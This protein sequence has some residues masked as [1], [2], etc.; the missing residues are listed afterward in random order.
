MGVRDTSSSVALLELQEPAE[1]PANHL[2]C[3]PIKSSQARVWK[4]APFPKGAEKGVLGVFLGCVWVRTIPWACS[5]PQ[6]RLPN[7]LTSHWQLQATPRQPRAHRC[8]CA[9]LGSAGTAFLP[10]SAPGGVHLGHTQG[11]PGRADSRPSA[12]ST[13]RA[14]L[15]L[16][17]GVSGAHQGAHHEASRAQWPHLCVASSPYS[18]LVSPGKCPVLCSTPSD[19]WFLLVGVQYCTPPPS[20]TAT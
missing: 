6:G 12:V 5:L 18:H 7:G 17:K 10:L 2:Q 4:E 11:T 16:T 1:G 3:W 8:S 14:S 13:A 20:A 19:T 9:P 15:G